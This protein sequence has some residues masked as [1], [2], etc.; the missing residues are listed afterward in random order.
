MQTNTWMPV[1]T[2]HDR[3]GWPQVLG[4]YFAGTSSP[5]ACM[6]VVVAVGSL[7]SAAVA[8]LFGQ[9]LAVAGVVTLIRYSRRLPRRSRI[10]LWL[11]V[12]TPF[13][14]AAAALVVLLWALAHS[15]WQF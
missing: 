7:T 9:A 11:G 5:G 15:N 4:W 10:A 8:S 6:A 1:P 3:P 12:I 13:L 2:T 14:L